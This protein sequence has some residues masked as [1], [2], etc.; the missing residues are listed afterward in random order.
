MAYE[1]ERRSVVHTLQVVS[2]GV[3]LRLVRAP[4]SVIFPVSSVPT[5]FNL[6]NASA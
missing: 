5:F 6:T 2:Q 1:A 4:S 3:W